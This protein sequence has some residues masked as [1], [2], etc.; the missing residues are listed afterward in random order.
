M[1]ILTFKH[2]AF[3]FAILLVIVVFI[4]SIFNL[5]FPV[6]KKD[7]FVKYKNLQVDKI[8][9]LSTCDKNERISL[10]NKD[11]FIDYIFNES[12]AVTFK[13]YKEIHSYNTKYDMYIVSFEL[14]N[15]TDK[16][17]GL[18]C[19]EEVKNDFSIVHNSLSNEESVFVKP[20]EKYII[21]I[22]VYIDRERVFEPNE[23]FILEQIDKIC[24]SEIDSASNWDIFKQDIMG[25]FTKKYMVL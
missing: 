8:G 18:F 11:I 19:V 6:L 5:I 20:G 14:E 2:K 4:I 17:L 12:R 1:K 23:K 10:F 16:T 15:N 22:T 21:C 9:V 7:V 13:E 24:F 25:V 3:V